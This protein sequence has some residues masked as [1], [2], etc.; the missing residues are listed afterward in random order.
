[1]L[2]TFSFIWCLHCL[3]ANTANAFWGFFLCRFCLNPPDLLL[4]PPCS[5]ATPLTQ[6]AQAHHHNPIHTSAVTMAAAAVAHSPPLSLL[7]TQLFVVVTATSVAID[8]I[9]WKGFHALNGILN[10]GCHLQAGFN[11]DAI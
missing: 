11:D 6:L 2:H 4:V 5:W 7:C 9:L 10:T 8:S 1:M 3:F